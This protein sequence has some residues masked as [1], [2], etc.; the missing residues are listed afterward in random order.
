[1]KRRIT[2]KEKKLIL[3]W[4]VLAPSFF[5]ISAGLNKIFNLNPYLSIV[6]GI[7]III[8]GAALFDF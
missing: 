8:I 7:V 3:M 2:K 6:I 4:L 5:L 1:M